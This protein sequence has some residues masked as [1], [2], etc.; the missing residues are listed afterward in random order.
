MADD[1]DS[2][3]NEPIL[4]REDADGICTLTLNR[5]QKRNALSLELLQALGHA[6]IKIAADKNRDTAAELLVNTDIDQ[7]R[8]SVEC[9]QPMIP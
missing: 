5:P 8:Q 4:L 7:C 2:G 6:L 1:T 9:Q 3:T